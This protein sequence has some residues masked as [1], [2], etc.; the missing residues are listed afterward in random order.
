[1]KYFYLFIL[2][3]F[4]P[5]FSIY[6]YQR[7]SPEFKD[8]TWSTKNRIGVW[9]ALILALIVITAKYAFPSFVYNINTGWD[10]Y[11]GSGEVN[12]FFHWLI[13]LTLL[14][15]PHVV[16]KCR[17]SN[18]PTGLQYHDRFKSSGYWYSGLVFSVIPIHTTWLLI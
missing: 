9:L 1:M 6:I 14:I 10:A 2:I 8:F 5:L 7:K 17:W 15:F 3:V 18:N 4:L 11:R 12:Y 13:A 16:K